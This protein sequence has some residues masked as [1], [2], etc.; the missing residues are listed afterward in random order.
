[1]DTSIHIYTCMNICI[2]NYIYIYMERVNVY[3]YLIYICAHIHIYIYLFIYSHQVGTSNNLGGPKD[4]SHWL[5]RSA[6]VQ[7][8]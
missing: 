5:C 2:Y 6:G 8:V 7:Q 3:K 1:M 4:V